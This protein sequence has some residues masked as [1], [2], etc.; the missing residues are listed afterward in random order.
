MTKLP[1]L[2]EHQ[3]QV[4]FVSDTRARY[5]LRDDFIPA[6]FFAVV[7]GFWVAG[8]DGEKGKASGRNF[9]MMAK[10][11]AEG[12]RKGVADLQYQQPRGGHPFCVIEMKRSDLRN[13]QGKEPG[14]LKPEQ[15][16]Y[17]DAARDVGAY[18]CVC[19]SGDEAIEAF[20]DYMSLPKG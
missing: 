13:Q 12:M 5:A 9:A 11:K 16:V 4:I 19:Y 10:Y 14:G 18:V 6:L 17:L 3:E 7:N 20:A 2:S 1:P 8:S 15:I